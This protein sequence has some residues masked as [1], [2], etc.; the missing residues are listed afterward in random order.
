MIIR[1]IKRLRMFYIRFRCRR[2][3]EAGKGFS[4]GRGTIFY[5]KNR[6]TISSK[7]CFGRYCSLECDADIGN[8]VL[9][10]N[11]VGFVGRL[12]HDYKKVGIP[13]RFAP[14]IRNSEYNVPESKS[15]VTVGD[16]VW[17]GYGAII[18]S[19]VTIGDGAIIGAGSLVTKDVELFSIVGGSLAKKI[20]MRFDGE[21]LRKHIK[22]CKEKYNSFLKMKDS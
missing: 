11:N 2:F 17:I 22:I 20:G 9:I 7:M 4:C 10:A 18:L 1:L 14:C 8:N 16:D 13:I 21:D 6:I 12:D 5:A 3:L 15:K 19:G